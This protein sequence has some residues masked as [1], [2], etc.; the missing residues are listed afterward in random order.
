MKAT[1]SVL[2]HLQC[3]GSTEH[4]KLGLS[5][6]TSSPAWS[7]RTSTTE[8]TSGRA[9]A[10]GAGAPSAPLFSP[11]LPQGN[12]VDGGV[13]RLLV[14][15]STGI[16]ITTAGEAEPGGTGGYPAGLGGWRRERP[17]PALPRSVPAELRARRGGERGPAE[18]GDRVPRGCGARCRWVRCAPCRVAVS[19]PVPAPRAEPE[20]RCRPR[21]AARYRIYSRPRGE[22]G[23]R[24]GRAAPPMGAAQGGLA[25]PS[26]ARP[27]PGG[28]GYAETLM[29]NS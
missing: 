26:S 21:R 1:G 16:R 5:V 23:G 15:G 22:R 29:V 25:P 6:R 8:R 4:K 3:D 9:R 11:I 10:P 28:R 27:P 24:D 18:R 20:P 17:S 14:L 12:A 19:L 13:K 7:A 2:L